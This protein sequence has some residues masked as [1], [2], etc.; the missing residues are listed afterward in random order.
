MQM[1][2][3]P[4]GTLVPAL[5][6]GTW[7]MGEDRGRRQG[8]INA[9]R[10][11]LDEGLSLIDTAEMYGEGA[12][13]EL[14]AQHA[15]AEDATHEL[16]GAQGRVAYECACEREALVTQHAAELADTERALARAK[17]ELAHSIAQQSWELERMRAAAEATAGVAADALTSADARKRDLEGVND[18]MVSLSER[19]YVGSLSIG[20]L[21]VAASGSP[22]GGL[23]GDDVGGGVP[24]WGPTGT[25]VAGVSPS[26]AAAAN[27]GN[28]GGAAAAAAAGGDGLQW[29]LAPA[30]PTLQ[31]QLTV[32]PS[33]RRPP[34]PPAGDT[35][36]Q[37]RGASPAKGGASRRHWAAANAT[38]AA[39][40][41]R[42]RAP[43]APP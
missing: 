23:G 12:A 33:K 18:A 5:G 9:L 37:R 8:E 24:A 1:V 29:E 19:L 30:P 31:R 3:W 15:I 40:R 25:G 14:V 28:G 36:P 17:A 6:Q 27:N 20:A 13:E 22:S 7:K 34:P 4:N 16:E 32:S 35:P 21:G 43:N 39:A 2:T 10:A 42:G 41:P 26:R 11:G 38:M